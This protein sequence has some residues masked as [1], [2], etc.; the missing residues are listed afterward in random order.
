MAWFVSFYW[1]VLKMRFSYALLLHFN[2]DA[3]SSRHETSALVQFFSKEVFLRQGSLAEFT[4]YK[5]VFM[6]CYKLKKPPV[7][8]CNY[9]SEENKCNDIY[10]PLQAKYDVLDRHDVLNVFGVG[11]HQRCTYT[12]IVK[13][14]KCNR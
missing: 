3:E 7:Q 10:T 4:L 6:Q 8:I 9:F 14:S 1:Q 2:A 12:F 11:F 5:I 13:R